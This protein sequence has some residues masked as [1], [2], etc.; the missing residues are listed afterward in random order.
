MAQDVQ[1]GDDFAPTAEEWNGFRKAAAL[2]GG[3]L[4]SG[5][6]PLP[7]RAVPGVVRVRN[8]GD[9]VLERYRVVQLLGAT[10]APSED[11]DAEATKEFAA[12]APVFNVAQMQSEGRPYGVMLDIVPPGGF[13]RAQ[14][15]GV[16][17]CKVS[18]GV[19]AGDRLGAAPEE[20]YLVPVVGGAAQALYVGGEAPHNGAWAVVMLGLGA[21]DGED[22]V[23][24]R[25]VGGTPSGYSVQLLPDGPDGAEGALV[26]ANAVQIG[27]AATASSSA[28][29][30]RYVL[31]HRVRSLEYPIEAVAVEEED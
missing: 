3:L 2:A 10:R 13:G 17:V 1:P 28:L 30:G 20:R 16:C 5:D 29:S 21:S 4:R 14:V 15:Y 24:G 31:V 9:V 7:G 23:L 22:V 11:E 6:G 26:V 18:N 19:A 12:G 27:A 25:I 8:T